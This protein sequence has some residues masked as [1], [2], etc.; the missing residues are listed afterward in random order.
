MDNDRIKVL[1]KQLKTILSASELGRLDIPAGSKGHINPDFI[2]G[3]FVN[4]PASKY[5]KAKIDID[6]VSLLTYLC[7]DKTLEHLVENVGK[8]KLTVKQAKPKPNAPERWYGA[9]DSN[10]WKKKAELTS[11]EHNPDRAISPNASEDDD[12][13]F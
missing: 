10:E 2:N 8:L 6:I 5:H 13:P 3:L 7:H 1:I 4:P 12:L 9:L 11:K